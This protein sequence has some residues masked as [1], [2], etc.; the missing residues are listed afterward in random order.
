MIRDRRKGAE[1]YLEGRYQDE[2]ADALGLS[3]A[4]VSRDLRHILDQ[5][6]AEAVKDVKEKKAVIERKYE[7]IWREA[8]AA[9]Q[10]KPNPALLGQAMAA[11]K[12]IREL[13]GT[14][15]VVRHEIKQ[16]EEITITSDEMA[17]ATKRLEEF[18][19][20]NES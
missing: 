18:I 6:Q 10:R 8:I 20:N 11:L 15:A 4:T 14:D 9:W 19:D 3:Q 12:G 16:V 13:L 1:F 17:A 7:F 2:I 5:W